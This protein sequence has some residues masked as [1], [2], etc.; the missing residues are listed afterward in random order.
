MG[1]QL[2]VTQRRICDNEFS[3]FVSGWGP[4]LIL[5]AVKMRNI[6]TVSR[7]HINEQKTPKDYGWVGF[8]SDFDER[9]Y[10][11]K[12]SNFSNF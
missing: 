2:D 8:I 11:K 3:N 7:E 4:F 1:I 5:S 9:Q 6:L 10:A 12:A